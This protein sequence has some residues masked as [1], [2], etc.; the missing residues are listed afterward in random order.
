RCWWEPFDRDRVAECLQEGRRDPNAEIRH[1]A[2]AALGRLGE[3][4]AVQWFRQALAAQDA[5]GMHEAIQTVAAEGIYLLWPDLDRLA[6]TEN[7]EVALHA[8]E[9]LERLREDLGPRPARA[10]L[11]RNYPVPIFRMF[12]YPDGRA[13]GDGG[14]GGSNGRGG[15]VTDE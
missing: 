3:C 9:A 1:T 13:A 4:K 12:P 5:Q 14:S 10:G 11:R 7:L 2:R 15:A 8:C 6:D